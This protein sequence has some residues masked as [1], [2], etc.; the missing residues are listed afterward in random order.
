MA[1]AAG[2][3]D[4]LRLVGGAGAGVG[5]GK[6]ALI[7]LLRAHLVRVSARAAE[8]TGATERIWDAARGATV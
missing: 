8:G 3:V 1:T 7:V 2:R 4:A 5:A 6:K